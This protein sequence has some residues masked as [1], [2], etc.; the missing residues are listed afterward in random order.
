MYSSNNTEYIVQSATAVYVVDE[1]NTSLLHYALLPHF[2][3]NSST[4][5][6][7]RGA[8]RR[9]IEAKNR[10]R[11]LPSPMLKIWYNAAHYYQHSG[12]KV[13]MNILSSFCLLLLSSL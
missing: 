2:F 12:L 4:G 11:L 1:A 13:K 9:G 10:P 5:I 3:R 7:S 6:T 8:R